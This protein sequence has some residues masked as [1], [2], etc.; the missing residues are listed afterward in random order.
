MPSLRQI[1]LASGL[2]LFA[3]VTPHFIDHAL[4]NISV[5]AMENGLVVQKAIWQTPPGTIVLYLSLLPTWASASGCS[6]N[7]AISAGPGSRRPSSFSACRFRFFSPI[8]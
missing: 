2:V 5:A 6:T 1:R 3:Y 8:T 7:A 4:G